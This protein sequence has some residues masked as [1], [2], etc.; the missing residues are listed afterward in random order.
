MSGRDHSLLIRALPGAVPWLVSASASA[1]PLYGPPPTYELAALY[2]LVS[3]ADS[4]VQQQ[5][6]GELL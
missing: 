4:L 2:D 1:A 3:K 5:L 6:T